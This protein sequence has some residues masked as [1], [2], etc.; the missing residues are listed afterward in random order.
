MHSHED[1]NVVCEKV[2][3]NLSNEFKLINMSLGIT[4]DSHVIAYDNQE[5][6][7]VFSSP[8][9][10]WTF[11]CF[12]HEAIS[13][14]NGGLRGWL[15]AGLSVES[16]EPNPIICKLGFIFRLNSSTRPETRY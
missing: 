4:N 11:R 6:F 10:W 14:L 1:V 9:V 3:Y 5:D 16:G 15:A 2:L 13:V 12:G 8:R 7:G